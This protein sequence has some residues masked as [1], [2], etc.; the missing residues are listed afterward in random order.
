MVDCLRFLCSLGRWIAINHFLNAYVLFFFG[1]W[2]PVDCHLKKITK[3][4][5]NFLWVGDPFGAKSAKVSWDI[6]SLPKGKGGLGIQN[7]NSI[8]DKM[9]V[10]LL[11]AALQHTEEEWSR[12]L[13]RNLTKFKF[14]EFKGWSHLPVVSIFFGNHAIT[15]SGS[16][17]LRS[18]IHA[19]N[20]HRD[21]LRLDTLSKHYPC[22]PP[23]DSI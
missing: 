11:V 13:L 20:R 22:V 8:A 3:I 17:L 12:L 4:C 19:W 18:L 10:K 16:D 9:S 2:R 6:C 7:L 21:C 1:C 15:S 5:R 14:S 23:N